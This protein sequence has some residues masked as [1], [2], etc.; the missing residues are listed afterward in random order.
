MCDCGAEKIVRRGDIRSGDTKSC[1]CWTKD[2]V[3]NLNKKYNN[4]TFENNVAIG[5]TT[6]GIRFIIDL[7]DYEK[8]KD[9]CWFENYDKHTKLTIYMAH[10][11]IIDFHYINFCLVKRKGL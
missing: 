5:I 8:C 7:L 9:I 2:R 1:G 6:N 10:K 4:W 3:K 11:T